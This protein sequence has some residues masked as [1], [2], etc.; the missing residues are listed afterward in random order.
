VTAASSSKTKTS[1]CCIVT[2]YGYPAEII[3]LAQQ[4]CSTVLSALR[5]GAEPFWKD[6]VEALRVLKIAHRSP[7]ASPSV[8]T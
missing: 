6:A 1:F 3:E 2:R 4:S 7:A 8:R 5:S